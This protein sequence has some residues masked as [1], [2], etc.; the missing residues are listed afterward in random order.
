M[1]FH[2][3]EIDGANFTSDGRLKVAQEPPAAPATTTP[4]DVG[5]IAS[6][7]GTVSDTTYVIT[8]TKTLVIQNFNGGGAPVGGGSKVELFYDPA[9]NGT[10]MTLV[11]VAYVYG[12]SF[13][14]DLNREFGPG[15]GVRAMRLRR[16]NLSGG[17]REIAGFFTGY[18]RS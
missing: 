12:N 8:N 6:V 11:R 3:V 18:E 2:I 16:T 17:A 7:S 14:F 9:G 10:G 13:S 1:A 5:G 4:V 15:N